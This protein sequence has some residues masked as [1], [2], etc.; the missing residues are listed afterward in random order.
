MNINIYYSQSYNIYNNSIVI[1]SNNLNVNK[2]CNKYVYISFKN[3][4]THIIVIKG[5]L[6]NCNNLFQLQDK[7]N[8]SVG[9]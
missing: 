7:V 4:Y 5:I 3:V 8:I 9:I 1:N 2:F 6:I